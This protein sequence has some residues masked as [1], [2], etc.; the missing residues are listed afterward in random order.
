MALEN[1]T[2]T[3]QTYAVR[4]QPIIPHIGINDPSRERRKNG[5]PR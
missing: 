2:Y 4:L 1:S 5:S 3:F